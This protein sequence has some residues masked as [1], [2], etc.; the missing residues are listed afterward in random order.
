MNLF[1][2]IEKSAIPYFSLYVFLFIA[3][4]FLLTF[5]NIY[6]QELGFS[7]GTIGLFSA[8]GPMISVLSQPV[9]GI[10]GDRTN[11]RFV[12][13]IL[14]VGAIVMSLVI[15]LNPTFVFIVV[16]LL[17]YQ[18]FATSQLPIV[19]A[20]T[21]QYLD[22]KQ[23]KYSAIRIIASISFGLAAAAAGP[24]IAGNVARIFYFN[25]FFMLITLLFAFFMKPIQKTTQKIENG[26][27]SDER[28]GLKAIV[29]LLENKVVLCVY[30]SS[31]VF[32]L[33]MS[34]THG[35]TGLRMIELGAT[36][37]QVGIALAIAAFAEIPLFLFI[38]RVMGKRKPEYILMISGFFMALRM[39]LMA[40]A[41]TI[42]VIYVAQFM[43]GYG[44]IMHLYFSIL[45]L[46]K[47]SPPHMKA[48]VQ[49]VNSMIRTGL[50]ALVGSLGG[51]FLAQHLS[52]QYVFMLLF[53]FVFSSCVV[54]PGIMILLSKKRQR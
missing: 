16:S 4:A 1:R 25:A 21:L 26:S 50:S 13:I 33:A 52:L 54:F 23:L 18:V 30:L 27:G 17:V 44:F 8:L 24:L 2:G 22:S 42:F 5:L 7:L 3:L 29:K 48:T 36:Q 35:F 40:L 12:L 15:P 39:L 47:H 41:G 9:W 31:F 6:F 34:F 53:I 51:G 37:A 49:T 20:M 43:H 11:K 46:H 38:D 14:L 32:G 19:D 28:S 10:I 45:L